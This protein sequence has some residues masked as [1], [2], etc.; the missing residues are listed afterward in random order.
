MSA[1]EQHQRSAPV[2][3]VQ[4]RPGPV[5]LRW[6]AVAFVAVLIGASC[7][8]LYG[9]GNGL[10]LKRLAL[11]VAVPAGAASVTVAVRRFEW[12]LLGLIALRPGLD[13]FHQSGGALDPATMVGAVFVLA[14]GGWLYVQWRTGPWVSPSLATWALGV[15]VAMAAASTL[16][17]QSV[18]TSATATVRVLAGALIF[19]VLEQLLA[20][21]PDRARRMLLAV[22]ASAAVPLAL[23]A[24]QIVRG[25]NRSYCTNGCGLD[26]SRVTGTFVHPN[27]FA[28][29]LAIVV[30]VIVALVPL[31]TGWQRV[32]LVLYGGTVG[33]VLIFTYARGAWLAVLV[34]LGYL[35]ARRRR[36][37]LL[38]LAAGLVVVVLAVPSVRNRF[39]DLSAPPPVAGVPSNSLSWR[40]GYWQ[41][42]LPL[43]DRDPINGI[44]LG[45]VEKTMQ[46]P[47]HNIYVQA[48]TETGVFGLAAL[49]GLIFAMGSTLRRRSRMA[50]GRLE[51]ALA[52]ASVAIALGLLVQSVSENLIDQTMAY[53]YFAAA[54]RWGLTNLTGA[55][56]RFER[57]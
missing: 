26:V 39:A 23:A 15:F 44:G 11:L 9:W 52:A 54:G 19:A 42:V 55:A 25:D 50:R 3:E 8:V 29:Y 12:F 57:S 16:T 43:A 27:P 24:M 17:S 4:A 51:Q 53:W 45:M 40:I 31:A 10:E 32:A 2:Q 6:T 7:A 36:E 49:L 13:L 22:L 47:P 5:L 46:L 18:L 33:T 30:V 21:R 1:T 48:Y 14:A 56:R 34:G 20:N 28:T 38:V 41:T 37:L 35:V